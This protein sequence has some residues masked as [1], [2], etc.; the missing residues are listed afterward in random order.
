M[1]LRILTAMKGKVDGTD[2]AHFEVGQVYDVGT[3][4]ANYLLASGYAEP[5]DEKMPDHADD[6][7]TATDVNPRSKRR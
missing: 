3:S 2:L 1:R 6:R 5:L 7:E 4:L